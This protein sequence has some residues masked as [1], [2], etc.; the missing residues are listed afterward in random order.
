MDAILLLFWKL[1]IA[2]SATSI[3]LSILFE[4]ISK[5]CEQKAQ[6]LRGESQ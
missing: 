4:L 1:L 5:Y 2:I 3:F 6:K